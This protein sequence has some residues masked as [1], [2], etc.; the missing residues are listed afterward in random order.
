MPTDVLRVQGD[1][2]IVTATAGRI[3]LDTASGAGSTTGTVVITG[4]LIVNGATQ[5]GVSP[6][7]VED[8]NIT[9]RVITLNF[10]DPGKNGG[11]Q[12]GVSGDGYSGIKIA[13]GFGTNLNNNQSAAYIE[14]N[15]NAVWN[16]T[17]V[18]G[19]VTGLFEFRVGKANPSYSAIKVNAIRIDPDS[20]PT[21]TTGAGQG[22]RL[23]IFGQDNPTA[24]ISV[25]GTNNY[26]ARV[27]DDDDIPNKKYVDDI[28]LGSTDT[29]EN[30]VVGQSYVK[31]IDQSQ[32]GFP[33]QLLGVLNGDPNQSKTSVAL[34]GTVVMR[35]TEDIAQFPGVQ[36][37]NNQIMPTAADTDLRLAADGTGQLVV[38]APFLFENTIPP[39]PGLGQTGLF[40]SNVGGGGT[41]VYFVSSSTLGVVTTDEFVSRK[42]ALI[43]ALI[44]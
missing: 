6:N 33:S 17:G 38:A 9:D 29:V 37:I 22:P 8:T 30:L 12:A 36:F 5:F 7:V 18:V 2:Q 10:N 28:L 34:T 31:I 4:D 32:D 13:R 25:K 16:G 42:R 40:V 24:V 41:G 19:P 15:E 43:F 11:T 23:N 35:I 27:T 44:F 14:W 21:N 26:A 39:S 20:A 3:T 1:Y